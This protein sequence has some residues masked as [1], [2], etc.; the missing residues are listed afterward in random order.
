[1]DFSGIRV[2][3]DT[4]HDLTDDQKIEA[5]KQAIKSDFPLYFTVVGKL[6]PF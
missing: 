5:A 3:I 4:N 1:M 2:G 6:I